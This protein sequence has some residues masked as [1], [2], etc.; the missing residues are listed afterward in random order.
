MQGKE[1]INSILRTTLGKLRVD[2]QYKIVKR[3]GFKVDEWNL[4]PH[5]ELHLPTA[6]PP[7]EPARSIESNK[8]N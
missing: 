8:S 1:L 6:Q 3:F 7:D 5:P 2:T 4:G